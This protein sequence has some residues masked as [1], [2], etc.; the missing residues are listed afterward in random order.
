VGLAPMPEV[1]PL[2]V[3]KMKR[4]TYRGA[5]ARFLRDDWPSSHQR[6]SCMACRVGPPCHR[7]DTLVC[8]GGDSPVMLRGA[9]G[10]I[11]L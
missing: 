8:I 2:V 7:V 10:G 3:A 5:V 1:G 6:A 4:H 9:S 11:C